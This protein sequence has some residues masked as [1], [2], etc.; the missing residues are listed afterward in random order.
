MEVHETDPVTFLLSVSLNIILW[1]LSVSNAWISI[2]PPPV[3]FP[4]AL[5]GFEFLFI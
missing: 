3:V 1:A 4:V 2:S 5:Q